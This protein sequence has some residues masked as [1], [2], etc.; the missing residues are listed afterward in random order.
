M[1]SLEQMCI[2]QIS[3]SKVHNLDE[4]ISKTC[5]DKF[6]EYQMRKGFNDWRKKADLLKVE[7]NI[8]DMEVSYDMHF[9]EPCHFI[10]VK[11][12]NKREIENKRKFEDMDDEYSDVEEDID[13]EDTDDEEYELFRNESDSPLYNVYYNIAKKRRLIEEDDY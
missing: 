1:D 7:L 10:F 12:K 8:K 9:D 3:N 5:Y 6:V 13:G 11:F 2:E 4:K